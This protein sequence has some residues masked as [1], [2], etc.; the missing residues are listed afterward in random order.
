MPL[1]LP[2]HFRV[3]AAH[4]VQASAVDHHCSHAD[5]A[6]ASLHHCPSALPLLFDHCLSAL[7]FHFHQFTF[8]HHPHVFCAHIGENDM[9]I[10]YD[11]PKITYGS[12]PD[13]AHPSICQHES[14]FPAAC[15]PGSFYSTSSPPWGWVGLY[16]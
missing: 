14:V 13:G 16:R 12:V 15:R 1:P 10:A 2:I 3:M 5:G 9:Y 11:V 6:S 7:K 4:R 8:P